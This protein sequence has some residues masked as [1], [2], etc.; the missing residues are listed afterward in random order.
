MKKRYKFLF[1]V[2]AASLLTTTTAF[3]Y[4]DD[5][6]ELAKQL[7]IFS[8]LYKAVNQNYVEE[9]NAA[10]L[11]DNAI[12]NMLKNLDPYTVYFN[13]QD[14]IRFKTNTIGEYTGIGANLY[15]KDGRLF[16]IEPFQDSAADK[17]GLKAGDEIIQIN[18]VKLVD[19]K[20]DISQ[21]LRG[22]KNTVIDVTYNRNGTKQ[23]TKI[24]LD[25]VEVKAVPFYQL[26]DDKKTG[27]IVLSQ[28]N[29]KTTA[30]VKEALVALKKQGATQIVLDLQNNPGGLL[31]EAVNLC[32]LFV[33]KNELI[34][35]TKSKD[36]KSNLSLRTQN[37]P[38]DTQIPLAILIN[39]KSAS[40]SEIVAGALQDLD[41]AVVVGNRSFGK[42]LVQRPIDLPYGTQLKVTISKYYTPSGRCI[43]ALDYGHKDKD[44]KAI[45]I[46]EKDYT[47]FK[48]KAG[49]VV[50]D[51]GG[52]LPDFIV[53][54][55]KQSNIVKLLDDEK[56]IF[57]FCTQLYN[58]NA[59]KAEI[60]TVSDADFTAFKNYIKQ[61]NIVL[62]SDSEKALME[63]ESTIKKEEVSDVVQQQLT[64]LQ[65]AIKNSQEIEIDK[66]KNEIKQ[67]ILEDLITRYQYKNGLHQYYAHNNPT[68]KKGVEVLN[69]SNLYKQ[70][71]KVK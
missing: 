47:A 45:K 28:F 3:T 21:L 71:L 59:N 31:Q 44:G 58:L 29:A 37:E 25:D 46:S 69:N 26:L 54:A 24:S 62:Q 39:E 60:K 27:Y 36:V 12:K 63:L 64:A 49:R 53:D 7:E 15:R 18:D 10:E 38:V 6:F 20:E 51:G 67:L 42:G 55:N 14:V 65:Q 32:N 5:F 19:F 30:E 48:T 56:V 13:E 35:T 33:N 11:M 40:A 43:Q 66:N 9:T 41:R 8:S 61:H 22:A 17:A 34:V 52:I 1:P 50:Y 70:T 68:V 4:K 16:V 2:I 23:T 57:N